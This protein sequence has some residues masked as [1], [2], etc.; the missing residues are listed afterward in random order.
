MSDPGTLTT[1][2]RQTANGRRALLDKLATTED[3]SE[4]FRDLARR[5][6]GSRRVLS[7]DEAAALDAAYALLGKVAARGKIAASPTDPKAA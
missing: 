6:A 2:Q 7:G 1:R 5:S 3:R 4:H